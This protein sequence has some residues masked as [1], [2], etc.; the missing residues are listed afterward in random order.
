LSE[1]SDLNPDAPPLSGQPQDPIGDMRKLGAN[2]AVSNKASEKPPVPSEFTQKADGSVT[3]KGDRQLME[4]Y[5]KAGQ[6][7]Q[8]AMGGMQQQVDRLKQ[9]EDAARKQPAWVQL[10]TAL[11]AN[12]AQQK[13]MPGWVKGLGQTAAQLNPRP[14]QLAAQR[15]GLMGEQADLAGK[16]AG[17]AMQEAQF[18]LAQRREGRLDTSEDRKALEDARKVE[19][20]QTRDVRDMRDKQLA[21]AQ[22]GEAAPADVLNKLFVERGVDPKL[23]AAQTDAI[24][25]TNEAAQARIKAER[26]WQESK[27]AGKENRLNRA[28]AGK[29]SD[30]A[31]ADNALNETA[32]AYADGDLAAVRDIASMRGNDRT[33]LFAK[34]KAL[35]PKFD[36]AEMN[37]KIKMQDYLTTGKG[38]DTIQYFGTFLQH[39]GDASDAVK[40]VQL[41]GSPY[42]NKPMNWWRKNMAGS[43]EFE[44]LRTSLEPAGVEFEKILIGTGYALQKEDRQRID[45]FLSGDMPVDQM[46]AA[47]KTMGGVAKDRYVELNHRAKRVLKK[48]IEDPFSED[49]HVGAAK[50]GLDLGTTSGPAAGAK[51]AGGPHQKVTGNDGVAEAKAA[52]I[53]D[54]LTI[55]GKRYKKRGENDFVEVK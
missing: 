40:Q 10:A 41:S 21:A 53:G 55:M 52:K 23:A 38:G 1:L 16:G 7:Y 4:Y 32:K 35:D 37:R 19:E 36:M 28:L 39:A 45:R 18:G 48:D 3:I 46:A 42:L 12:L 47:L 9:Q 50:I 22:K 44:R 51:D 8:Q 49:A 13:D 6:F 2:L 11:S 25:K 33:R 24:T 26:V 17:L 34:I 31:E 14:E 43:P 27:E 54:T 29:T 20:D 5:G 15:M 30:K